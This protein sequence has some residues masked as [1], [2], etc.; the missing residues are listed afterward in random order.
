MMKKTTT[1]GR[2]LFTRERALLELVR[3]GLG[4]R[5]AVM[6]AIASM[7]PTIDG[8]PFYDAI[9]ID[10]APWSLLAEHEL[11]G[12]IARGMIADRERL[13]T[14]ATLEI[15][16]KVRAA[17]DRALS[18]GGRTSRLHEYAATEHADP[19]VYT[20]GYEGESIDAFLRR[21]QGAGIERIVDVRA[22]AYSRKYGFTGGTFRDALARVG[23][24]YH[25]EPSLG[26]PTALRSG[27]L[28][29]TEL[30]ERY[31]S[32]IVPRAPEALDRV[33]AAITERASALMCFE[34][35]P[36]DCHRGTLAPMLAER[37][38]LPIMHLVDDPD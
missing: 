5:R 4:T 9:A 21:M 24:D 8:A 17:V 18:P 3:R 29:K 26:V 16:D 23:I 35:R 33:I 36:E 15:P 38:R 13:T 32:S 28:A 37:T 20:T 12:L 25:H 14:D 6:D 10:G 34:A 30:F 19:A 7:G 11:A 31:A 2:T 1:E 27:E 22:H